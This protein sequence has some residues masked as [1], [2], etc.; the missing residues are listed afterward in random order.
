MGV[1]VAL[2]VRVGRGVILG[3]GAPVTSGVGVSV[4]PGSAVGRRVGRAVG[5]VVGP[6]VEDVEG[7]SVTWVVGGATD[8]DP[9]AVRGVALGAGPSRTPPNTMAAP[10]T[11]ATTMSPT[12]AATI[13]RPLPPD[14][15]GPF[16]GRG[17]PATVPTAGSSSLPQR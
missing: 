14:D 2:G 3:V 13:R 12:P 1:A 10:A 15:A 8:G 5:R 17:V 6:S 4:S 7:S 9:T 16:T 11:A